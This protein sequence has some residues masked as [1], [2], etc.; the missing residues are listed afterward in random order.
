MANPSSPR[1]GAPP[2]ASRRD[3]D[4]VASPEEAVPLTAAE[5]PA[6]LA[7]LRSGTLDPRAVQQRIVAAVSNKRLWQT[8]EWK[9]LRERLLK[10]HCEQCGTT[11][12]PFTL[13]HLWHPKTVSE[14][15]RGLREEHREQA[16]QRFAAEHAED[17]AYQDRYERDGDPRPGCPRCGGW[18]LQ[19]RKSAKALAVMARY[20]CLT[21]RNGRHCHHEFNEAVEVQPIKLRDRSSFV[22]EA[23][24]AAYEPIYQATTDA[25]YR[26]A[27][28]RAVEEFAAYMTGE[29]VL[30]FCK[31]CAYMWDKKGLRLCTECRDGWHE[32]HW[33]RCKACATGATWVV[34]A[35][36][37]SNRHLSTASS[38]FSCAFPAHLAE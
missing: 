18:S 4:S 3:C 8:P 9:E 17:P 31:R 32:H 26:D 24:R 34:C 36:C 13:Q 30:T 11:E 14:W 10:P 2:A 21:Q 25:I 12:E 6:V 33:A 7:A 20:R 16:W 23:F 29:G 35:R 28:I 15:V 5:C 19:E 38:C 1:R 27:T 22:W 37:S